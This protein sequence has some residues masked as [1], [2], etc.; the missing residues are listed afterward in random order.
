MTVVAA[1]E[2]EAVEGAADRRE[3]GL[4]TPLPCKPRQFVRRRLRLPLLTHRP[5]KH[6]RFARRL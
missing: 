1:E 3:E 6:L 5:C 2:G 4:S